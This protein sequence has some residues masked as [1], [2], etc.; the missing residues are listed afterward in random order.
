MTA[1]GATRCKATTVPVAWSEATVAAARRTTS[2]RGPPGRVAAGRVPPGCPN[3]G[4]LVSVGK[5]A[6]VVGA[7]STVEIALAV[8]ARHG[9]G[10]RGSCGRV[11]G[12]RWSLC[13][14]LLVL[15]VATVSFD[16]LVFQFKR[17]HIF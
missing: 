3:P 17:N 15:H 7:F 12:A 14:L 10:R 2:P 16:A 8:P 4:L 5:S 9:F 6:L 11:A 13:K 1:V